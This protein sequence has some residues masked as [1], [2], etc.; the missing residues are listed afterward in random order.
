M[1][2]LRIDRLNNLG[3]HDRAPFEGGGQ[4]YYHVL[5]SQLPSFPS[6]LVPTRSTASL[7]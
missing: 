5:G 2:S 3:S 6:L 4:A 1:S 7:T